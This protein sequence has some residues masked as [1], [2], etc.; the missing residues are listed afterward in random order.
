MCWLFNLRTSKKHRLSKNRK[1][2]PFLLTK[3]TFIGKRYYSLD[4]HINGYL[5]SFRN[6][7]LSRNFNYAFLLR[8]YSP[9]PK[10]LLQFRSKIWQKMNF[11]K[12]LNLVFRNR[13]K[14][15]FLASLNRILAILLKF[16]LSSIIFKNKNY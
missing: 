6:F 3:I 14:T 10:I 15:N 5:V 8:S 7:C 13:I 11:E 16:S 2:L 9:I 12:I 4:S 1:F